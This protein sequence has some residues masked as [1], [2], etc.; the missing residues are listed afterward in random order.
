MSFPHASTC[1]NVTGVYVLKNTAQLNQTTCD[2]SFVTHTELEKML[3]RDSFV[4]RGR[5]QRHLSPLWDII[6]NKEQHKGRAC[7]L[8]HT[9]PR[10]KGEIKEETQR[11]RAEVA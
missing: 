6:I 1:F 8:K 5:Q 2:R 11:R 7:C 3:N 9:Y 4:L 10:F